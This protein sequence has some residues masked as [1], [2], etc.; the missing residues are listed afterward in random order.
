MLPLS[1]GSPGTGAT[2][3]LVAVG[4]F[5]LLRGSWLETSQVLALWA[6]PWH[7]SQY[8]SES[9]S[10]SKSQS[11]RETHGERSE[12]E[13]CRREEVAEGHQYQEV[14]TTGSILEASCHN[15]LAT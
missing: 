12:E 6:S 8:Q 11:Q 1:P 15:D 14:G 7:S 13:A 2:S 5:P 9:K 4:P 10:K 3:T